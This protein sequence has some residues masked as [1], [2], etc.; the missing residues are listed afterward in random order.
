M[1]VFLTQSAPVLIYPSAHALQV[2]LLTHPEH[3]A[4]QSVHPLDPRYWLSPQADKGLHVFSSGKK[5]VWHNVH[6]LK[7][8]SHSL[9]TE[10][11]AKHLFLDASK[12]WPEEH[13]LE[14]STQS[15]PFWVNSGGHEAT[16][17]SGVLKP[18][19]N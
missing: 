7:S 5:P 13:Y 6:L 4:G 11:Q 14:L 19:Q 8:P 16:Q 10:E 2:S 1:L 15:F 12:Y 3:L 18:W 17:A 9:Q